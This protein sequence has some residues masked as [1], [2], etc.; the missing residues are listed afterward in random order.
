[1]QAVIFLEKRRMVMKSKRYAKSSSKGGCAELNTQLLALVSS[2]H[3]DLD[4]LYRTL[5]LFSTVCLS[6][7]HVFARRNVAPFE[8]L[9]VKYP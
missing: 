6:E 9:F 5:L 7:E 8:K 1:M 3:L 2:W 4:H